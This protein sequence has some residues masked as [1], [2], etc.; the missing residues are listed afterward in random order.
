[1]SFVFAT[2]I[3]LLIGAAM[4]TILFFVAEFRAYQKSKFN[5]N[6][7]YG[8]VV[9]IFNKFNLNRVNW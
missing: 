5:P 3:Y 6:C 8:F 2:I 1:M 9:K 4:T 7:T